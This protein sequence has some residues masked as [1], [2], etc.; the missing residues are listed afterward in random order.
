MVGAHVL[1]LRP[2]LWTIVR[3]ALSIGVVSVFY[4]LYFFHSERSREFLFGIANAYFYIVS[5]VWI[6]PYALFTVRNRAW[7]TR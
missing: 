3:P 6:F 2:G 7:M 5:L 1:S 4:T